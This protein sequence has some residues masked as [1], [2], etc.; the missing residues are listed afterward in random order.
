[1]AEEIVQGMTRLPP[2]PEVAAAL[3]RLSDSQPSTAALTN[4]PLEVAEAQLRHA[5]LRPYFEHVLSADEARRL[6]P[7]PEPYRMVA[8]RFAVDIADVWLVAAHAWDVSGALA[9]GCRAAFVARPGMT[10][11][12]L[13]QQPDVVGADLVD[14]AGQI[15]EQLG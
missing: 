5:G 10:P 15:L 7:A 1:M 3:E 13:G 11:S 14:V 4:S 12:P 6:K 8:D 9:A 2:H